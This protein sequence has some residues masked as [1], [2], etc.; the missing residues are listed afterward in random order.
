MA[1]DMLSW[2][3][4]A[5]ASIESRSVVSALN[6]MMAVRAGYFIVPFN[7]FLHLI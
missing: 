1:S 6:M 2:F 5:I 7:P 4:F 3:R